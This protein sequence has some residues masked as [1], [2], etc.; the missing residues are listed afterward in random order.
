VRITN[1]SG[2]T[3]IETSISLRFRIAMM[4]IA[5]VTTSACVNRLTSVATTMSRNIAMSPVRRINTSP[6]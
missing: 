5:P 2:I 6:E 1:S 3:A 4:T